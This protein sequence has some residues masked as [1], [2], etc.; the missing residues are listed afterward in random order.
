MGAPISLV[1]DVIVH[2][3]C[4]LRWLNHSTTFWREL[5]RMMPDYLER[6][7]QLAI[8]GATFAF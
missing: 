2:E 5:R 4:H 8:K 7:R 1:D 3:L 6:E